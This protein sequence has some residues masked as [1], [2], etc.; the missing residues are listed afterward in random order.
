MTELV[1]TIYKSC[2][3]I[4]NTLRFHSLI[5]R[6]SKARLQLLLPGTII[7]KT[8]SERSFMAVAPKLRNKLATHIKSSKY[9]TYFRE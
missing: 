8:L 2:T 3:R 6:D 7:K 4:H 1:R 9:C 5:F